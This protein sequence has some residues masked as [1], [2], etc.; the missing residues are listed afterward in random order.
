VRKGGDLVA[1][2]HGRSFWILED[3][4]IL[5]QLAAGERVEDHPRLFAPAPAPRYPTFSWPEGETPGLDYGHTGPL[6]F[7]IRRKQLP[8]GRVESRPLDAGENPPDGMAVRY[9]LPTRPEGDATLT[10]LDEQGEAIRSFSSKKEKPAPASEEEITPEDTALQLGQEGGEGAPVGAPSEEKAEEQQPTI[11]K[12]AG[13]NRFIW[14]MRAAPAH[15]VEG[16][17]SMALFLIG[18]MVLPGRYQVRLTVG[19]QSWTQPFEIIPDPRGHETAE[20]RQAQYDLLARINRKLSEAHDAVNQIRDVTGQINAWSTRVKG[21][22]RLTEV[23][24]AA[25]A[26][27]KTLTTIEEAIFKTEPDADLFY[28]AVMKLSGRLAALK[29]AVDF[30]N[31]APTRQAVEVYEELTGKIDGQ[32]GRLGEV[33]QTDLAQ[34]N[35]RIRDTELPAIAPRVSEEVTSDAPAGRSSAVNPPAV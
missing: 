18:P 11:A 33:L 24:R 15:K 16:D 7:G 5:H 22:E 4:A 29:F 32:L 27:K 17:A 8:S 30:N 20:A 34:L 12:E 10:F 6:V 1:A 23:V 21:Q 14:D 28:T 13:L 3:V 25:D 35:Q 9:W 31:Y 2:T 19:D 26:L